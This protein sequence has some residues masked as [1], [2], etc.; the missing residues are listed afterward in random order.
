MFYKSL[1]ATSER[2]DHVFI[3]IFFF[4]SLVSCP[5]QLVSV[6]SACICDTCVRECLLRYHVPSTCCVHA[7]SSISTARWAAN[8][9]I[10][11]TQAATSSKTSNVKK[12]LLTL[13][14]GESKSR[15]HLREYVV[16]RVKSK[17]FMWSPRECMWE[18]ERI[19]VPWKHY[20]F[21]LII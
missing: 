19:V 20:L 21:F 6:A 13:L 18:R 11:T 4:S 15:V 5:W 7:K 17:K 2:S 8:G 10:P 12:I 16:S 14:H 3:H 9:K 1:D